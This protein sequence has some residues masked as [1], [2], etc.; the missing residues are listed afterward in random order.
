YLWWFR[1][2][3]GVYSY[4]SMGDGGNMIC[5]IPEKELVVVMA[6]EVVPETKDRWRLI[7]EYILLKE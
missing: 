3:E 6:S 1:E 4:C 7:K 2:E 5:C